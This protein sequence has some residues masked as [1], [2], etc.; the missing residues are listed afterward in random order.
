MN[1]NSTLLSIIAYARSGAL[2]HAWRLF[3]DAGFDGTS[4]DP[5]VLSVRGRLLKDQALGCDGAEREQLYLEAADAYARAGEMGGTTYPLIN[6]ATLSFLAGRHEQAQ[7]LARQVLEKGEQDEPETPY[8]RAATRAEALLLL[9]DVENAKAAFADAISQAPRAFE[10][11]ASTL[12]QLAL[13]LDEK[14]EDKTWLDPW[15]PPRSLHFAG[16]MALAGEGEKLARTI[17]AVIKEERVGFGYGALAAGADILIAESLLE[18]GAELH[19]VLPTGRDHFRRVS[20]ARF[21]ERWATRYDHI[22]EAADSVRSITGGP[23]LPTQLTLQLAAEVA[24]GLAAMQADMLTTEAVQLLILDR[25][26]VAGGAVGSSSWIGSAW[27]KSGRRQHRLTASRARMR[28]AVGKSDGADAASDCLAAVLR[29]DLSNVNHWRD[30]LLPRLALTLA[31]APTP[32]IAPRWTGDAVLAAYESATHAARAALSVA[33]SLRDVTDLCVAGHYGIVRCLE[34]PFEGGQILIGSVPRLLGR[35]VHSVPQGAI[36][37][38]E[39]FA[40][41]LHAASGKGRPRI[42]YVGDLPSDGRSDPIK[43][44]SLK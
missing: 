33:T 18:D 40:V 2:D 24:M 37:V 6:A 35:I 26:M 5:A 19:I 27:E 36:H 17:R 32:F 42:E 21:G 14:G 22:L 7:S 9:G 38:T 29:V 43:L 31:A 10:D 28:S 15:R 3:Q 44:F 41:A 23:A 12:R 4:D 20:V 34:D 1:V 16:L 25:N 13:I 39:D 30:D 8:Y 11:H